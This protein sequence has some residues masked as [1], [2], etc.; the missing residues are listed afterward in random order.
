MNSI[1]TNILSWI[2][3]FNGKVFNQ[4]DFYKINP[5]YLREEEPT[6]CISL[7]D[8]ADRYIKYLVDDFSE[9][10]KESYE[11][12]ERL[13]LP[14]IRTLYPSVNGISINHDKILWLS[15]LGVNTTMEIYVLG[16]ILE[17]LSPKIKEDKS[18]KRFGIDIF[19]V[20]SALFADVCYVFTS[21]NTIE[22][23]HLW[24]ENISKQ[25]A[26]TPNFTINCLDKLNCKIKFEGD[27]TELYKI[28][29][30]IE[31]TMIKYLTG[32]C[33]EI[34]G[35]EEHTVTLSVTV[36]DDNTIELSYPKTKL[37]RDYYDEI[38]D[39]MNRINTNILGYDLV[40]GGLYDKA[41]LLFD[42]KIKCD[43]SG[44]EGFFISEMIDGKQVYDMAREEDS[45][46]WDGCIGSCVMIDV[47]QNELTKNYDA[48]H[49]TMGF[50]IKWS[51]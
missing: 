11:M 28:P 50:L 6:N 49:M 14:A 30:S 26:M 43:I 21:I 29:R 39:S 35:E 17:F 18:I 45:N 10:L 15:D 41:K 2:E 7:Q 4:N 36:S 40:D 1:A 47:P 3:D 42:N 51:K 38:I 5:I 12:S 23:F 32:W 46:T 20:G 22:E 44:Y 24:V 34:V 27:I 9:G 31:V 48:V 37:Y 25:E 13:Y 33:D 16:K 8:I 19:N